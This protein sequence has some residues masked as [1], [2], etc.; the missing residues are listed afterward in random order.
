MKPARHRRDLPV[1]GKAKINRNHNH[2]SQHVKNQYGPTILISSSTCGTQSDITVAIEDDCGNGKISPH[3]QSD[4]RLL[5]NMCCEDLHFL[6]R[7]TRKKNN[8][9]KE[10]K[11]V[12]LS[13]TR[14][15]VIKD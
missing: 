13:T 12:L 2:A 15:K 1:D 14:T 8:Q 9:T 5:P 4:S 10:R 7:T 6:F 3:R 11:E